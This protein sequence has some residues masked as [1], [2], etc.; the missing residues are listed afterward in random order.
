MLDD[1]FLRPVDPSESLAEMLVADAAWRGS[2]DGVAAK[3]ADMAH[4][5]IHRTGNS[6]YV[7]CRPWSSRD[8]ASKIYDAL[9]DRRWSREMRRSLSFPGFTIDVSDDSRQ[10]RWFR[11]LVGHF[12]WVRRPSFTNFIDSG[13]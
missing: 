10:R 12:P 5:E 8:L 2:M 7:K 4:R 9:D 13:F 1:M 3:V 6:V 11:V